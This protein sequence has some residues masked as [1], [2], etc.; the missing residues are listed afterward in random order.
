MDLYSFGAGVVISVLL[1]FL[2]C[3]R[4]GKL[5]N[6]SI[7]AFKRTGNEF[8]KHQAKLDELEIRCDKLERALW[9]F[10]KPDGFE[11]L[12]SDEG[13]P[14]DGSLD[15]PI[16]NSNPVHNDGRARK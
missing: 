14:E 2:A 12:L 11:G 4:V 16:P 15:T 6:S 5:Q 1:Y 8:F 9:K 7:S 10:T 13:R 3:D